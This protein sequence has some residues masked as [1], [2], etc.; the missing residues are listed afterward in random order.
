MTDPHVEFDADGEMLWQR[1][2]PPIWWAAADRFI[3]ADR[4]LPDGTRQHMV[5]GGVEQGTVIA[6]A[7]IVGQDDMKNARFS[8]I[9]SH[10]SEVKS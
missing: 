10:L 8:A 1:V 2:V 6:S 5:G 3:V 4:H 7:Q 9:Q